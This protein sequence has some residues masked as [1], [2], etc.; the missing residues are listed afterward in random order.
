MTDDQRKSPEPERMMSQRH[1]D[2]L[3]DLGEACKISYGVLPPYLRSMV[4]ELIAAQDATR[5]PQSPERP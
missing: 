2:A 5:F 4:D 1:M 3:W